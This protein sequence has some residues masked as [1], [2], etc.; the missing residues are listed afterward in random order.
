MT[1]RTHSSSLT[2]SRARLHCAALLLS[3]FALC[4]FVPDTRGAVTVRLARME[5][6]PAT[7]PQW[8][9][10]SAPATFP[11][12]KAL[13]GTPSVEIGEI[14]SGYTFTLRTL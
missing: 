9:A 1:P 8:A 6:I 4:L 7:D 11:D 3:G 14:W 10:A 5:E 2:R 12:A 13:V